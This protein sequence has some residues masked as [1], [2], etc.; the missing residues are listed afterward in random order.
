M[1]FGLRDPEEEDQR[2]EED[3]Q[4]PHD[5]GASHELLKRCGDD[6]RVRCPV[7]FRSIAQG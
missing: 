1:L 2:E 7:D 4:R 5:E 6:R 3:D